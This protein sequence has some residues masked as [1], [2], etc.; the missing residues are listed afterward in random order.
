MRRMG[1]SLTILALVLAS[2]SILVVGPDGSVAASG[3]HRFSNS[4]LRG[5]HG[6]HSTGTAPTGE[7]FAT[8]GIF[9]FDGDGNLTATLFTRRTA[10]ITVGP[11]NL[12]GTYTVNPNCTV[13][14]TW[15]VA[16]GTSA[17]HESVVFDEGRGYFLINTSAVGDLAVIS[18]EGRKQ[19]VRDREEREDDED[20]H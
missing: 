14:D 19:F 16:N 10:G 13:S 5:S 12:T 2:L 3:A 18:G 11:L 1:F 20:S 9:R 8:V 4:S 17:T 15:A 7:P 6:F